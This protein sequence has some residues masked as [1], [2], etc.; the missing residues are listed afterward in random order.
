MSGSRTYRRQ[1]TRRHRLGLIEFFECSILC[2]IFAR[3][4]FSNL[5]LTLDHIYATLLA[6]LSPVLSAHLTA[7]Y[8]R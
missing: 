5:I 7:A 6:L 8:L 2:C 3:Y 4:G 1:G